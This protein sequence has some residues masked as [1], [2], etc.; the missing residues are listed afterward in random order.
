M[1]D[2]NRLPYGPPKEAL[3]FGFQDM[4]NNALNRDPNRPL[5]IFDETDLSVTAREYKDIVSQYAQALVSAGMGNNIRF[6]VLS[7]NRPEVLFLNGALSSVNVCRVSMHP[8][9]SVDDFEYILNDSHVEALIIDPDHFQ[10]AAAELQKR[11]PHLKLVLSLGP[12]DV[13][14]DLHALSQTFEPGVPL[15]KGSGGKP[16]HPEQI[17]AIGYSGGTTGK[18]KA[19]CQT[20]RSGGTTFNTMMTEWEWPEVN[21]HMVCA[22][23]SHGGGAMVTPTILK[24]GT[25]VVLSG[26]DAG[27][28]L[29]SIEKHRI[30]SLWLVPAMIYA[31]LD[32]PD[33]DKHDLSSIEIIYYGA[34]SISPTRLKEA[35]ERIGPVFFQFYGQSEAPMSVSIMRRSE[36]DPNDLNR[37][38]SCGRPCLSV[39]VALLDNDCNEVEDGEP[40][41]ICVRGPLLM[42][43]YLNKPEETAEVF[44]GGWLHTGDV[45]VKDPDGF[46]RI[47]DRK[48]DMIVTGGFNVFP[49]EIED[50]L[51]SH[52]SVLAAAAF[53]VPD[54]KWGEKVKAV[55]VTKASDSVSADELIT[56]VKDKKGSVQAPKSV[57]FI[58]EIPLSPLGKPDKKALRKQYA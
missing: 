41:E 57:D 35:I 52:P 5:V 19:I 3:K 20:L 25:L 58:D 38:A 45:A 13:G 37:L 43:G 29:A 54:E 55:V 4:M 50:V 34:S 49:R 7:K 18:P 23:L 44:E 8:M 53:G 17:A 30:T 40:G 26:F 2:Q 56:L 48:K 1:S 33:F 31:L 14:T 28:V 24:G 9:G 32:H 36:H 22:P 10:E 6:G 15:P 11:V 27:Q 16:S 21:R 42:G 12:T 51:T 39:R 46:L 47:V